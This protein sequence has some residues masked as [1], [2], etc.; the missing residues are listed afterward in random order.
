MSLDAQRLPDYLGHIGQA[1]NAP[2]VAPPITADRIHRPH[3][4][5]GTL[6]LWWIL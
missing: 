6:G 5:L 2:T 4:D 1:T 3:P